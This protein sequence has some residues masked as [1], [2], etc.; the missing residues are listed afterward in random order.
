MIRLDYL[1]V[2]PSPIQT[3]VKNSQNIEIAAVIFDAKYEARQRLKMTFSNVGSVT[4][5]SLNITEAL[6]VAECLFCMCCLLSWD[7]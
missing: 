2:N 5:S 4:F 6:E 3:T 1:G 7:I